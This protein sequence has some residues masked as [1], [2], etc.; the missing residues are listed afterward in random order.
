MQNKELIILLASNN[1]A[2]ESALNTVLSLLFKKYKLET[3][4][5]ESGVS[6]TPLTDEEAIQGCINR[7]NQIYKHSP[8][9]SIYVSMEGL[10][11]KESFGCFVYGWAAI[12]T[13][14]SPKV[15]YG[16]SGKVML[17]EYIYNKCLNGEELSEIIKHEYI[18]LSSYNELWGTNGILTSGVYTR[19]DEFIT[20]LSCAFGSLIEDNRT[21][22]DSTLVNS[23]SII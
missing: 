21:I 3:Y 8:L 15:Y 2:K 10:I 23:K 16:C 1:K 13:N 18:K 14:R 11:K 5:S 17:P 6:N 7:I 22:L 19:V 12:K 20:A 4:N 9:F